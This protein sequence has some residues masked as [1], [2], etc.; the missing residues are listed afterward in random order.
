MCAVRFTVTLIFQ[1][2]PVL[3]IFLVLFPVEADVLSSMT[4]RMT[5]LILQ[6]LT[7]KC[8]NRELL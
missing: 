2:L 4:G 1:D 5:I 8:T 3:Q 6:P 7:L